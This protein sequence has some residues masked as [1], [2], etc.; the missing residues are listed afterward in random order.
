MSSPMR[1][2]QLHF[3]K[4]IIKAMSSTATSSVDSTTSIKMWQIRLVPLLLVLS[5]VSQLAI[6]KKP[7][8]LIIPNESIKKSESLRHVAAMGIAL[9]MV[10]VNERMEANVM[11]LLKNFTKLAKNP[12]TSEIISLTMLRE[13]EKTMKRDKYAINIL[14]NGLDLAMNAK[15]VRNYRQTLSKMALEAKNRRPQK[16]TES[17]LNAQKVQTAVENHLKFMRDEI[18]S[19]REA[20][21][22]VE[23]NKNPKISS[24]SPKPTL[25]HPIHMNGIFNHDIVRLPQLIVPMVYEI[26]SFYRFRRQNEEE[27]ED[28]NRVDASKESQED[29]DDSFGPPSEA[30]GGGITGLIASLSGGEGGSDVGALIGAI[31]GIITNLFGPGGLDVPTLLSSGTSLIAGLLGEIGGEFLVD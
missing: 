18:R 20:L 13:L 21:K 28:V 30:A 11:A 4:F 10:K 15:S 29:F 25:Q 22:E 12:K 3:R 14:K 16:P 31:S 9:G 2:L 6:S 1:G 7:S 19:A 5:T 8:D 23:S 24:T 27:S 26:E 17:D